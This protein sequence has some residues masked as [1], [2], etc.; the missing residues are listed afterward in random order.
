MDSPVKAQACNCFT[1]KT[2]C[3]SLF[4]ALF[5]FFFNTGNEIT[6]SVGKYRRGIKENCQIYTLIKKKKNK[7]KWEET[8]VVKNRSIITCAVDK[9]NINKKTVRAIYSTAWDLCTKCL[10]VFP[11]GMFVATRLNPSWLLW[12]A[13]A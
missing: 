5:L 3:S 4:Q 2:T 11:Y 10:V 6:L 12:S 13:I 1:L 8:P 9:Y 7:K